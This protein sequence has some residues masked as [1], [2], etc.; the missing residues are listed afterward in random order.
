MCPGLERIHVLGLEIIY[1]LMYFWTRVHAR[2]FR[3]KWLNGTPLVV[4]GPYGTMFK[5]CL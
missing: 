3:T 1:L 5:V 2:R 4:L